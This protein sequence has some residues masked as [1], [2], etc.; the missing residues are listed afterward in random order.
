MKKLLFMLLS[1]G[2]II[3][4]SSNDDSN[5]EQEQALTGHYFLRLNGAGYEN[6]SVELVKDTVNFIGIGTIF[7]GSDN[8]GNR[9]G[10]VVPDSGINET[11]IEQLPSDVVHDSGLNPNTSE[12]LSGTNRYL[13]QSG[14]FVV[15]ANDIEDPCAYWKGS[16]DINYS[17]DGSS[18]ILNIQ[19][20]FEVPASPCYLDN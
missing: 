7:S 2:F 16:L 20:T 11:T 19:G 8:L 4:C 3:A 10:I 18:N 15:S 12:F 14:T 1:F 9:I 13:S 5:E 17:L 6:E